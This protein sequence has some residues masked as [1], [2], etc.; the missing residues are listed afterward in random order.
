[1]NIVYIVSNVSYLSG[2]MRVITE[3]VNRLSARGHSVEIWQQ[4]SETPY[5]ETTVP[6]RNYDETKLHEPEVV[7]LTDPAFLIDA[8]K[9][10]KNKRT[11]LLLQHDFAW[12]AEVTGNDIHA[13]WFAA[14]QDYIESGGCKVI[15][16][17]KWLQEVVK[18]RY[19]AEAYLVSNGIDLEI[20]HPTE[21]LV[22]SDD[23]IALF[24]Y[25]PQNWKGFTE[26]VQALL[27]VKAK[28]PNLKIAM[29]GRSYPVTPMQD[30]Q[31]YGFSFPSIY[32]CRPE[33]NELASIYSSANV[34]LCASW[35]EG[36]GLPGLEALACGVPLVTTDAGGVR[37]YAEDE[38]TAI[39]A[40]PQDINAISAALERVLGDKKLQ[41]KL[42]HNGL[43]RAADFDWDKNIQT[44]ETLL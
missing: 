18:E 25:D 35:K 26:A 19:G 43:K 28:R 39:I 40:P 22:K 11:H 29:V 33:Q 20:F 36:F 44:L 31:Y 4:A 9:S 41:D 7:V 21:P 5:F 30:G 6:I 34:F 8:E 1:M 12:L 32:F 23:D 16:V 15:V 14:H 27:T 38:E 24:M 13:N 37:D 3:H 2:G 42:R 17:S 10:R